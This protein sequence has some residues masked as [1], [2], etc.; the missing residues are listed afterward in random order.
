LPGLSSRAKTSVIRPRLSPIADVVAARRSRL[1]TSRATVPLELRL[2]GGHS[3]LEAAV[4]L[5]QLGAGGPG[6]LGIRRRP[7]DLV[8]I[9]VNGLAAAA[10]LL[11]LSAGIALAPEQSGRGVADP[12]EQR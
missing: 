3:C 4:L 1:H 6:L 11:H 2:Q 10:G 7:F 8:R 12:G 5:E 9:V